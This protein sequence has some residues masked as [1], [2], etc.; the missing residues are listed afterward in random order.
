MSL[1]PVAVG[2]G[3]GS[4]GTLF[5]KLV[6]DILSSPPPLL[7]ESLGVVQED[8]CSCEQDIKEGLQD[9]WGSIHTQV[10]GFH[11]ISVLVGIVIGESL[12][13]LLELIILFRLR[14]NRYVIRAQAQDRGR[15]S[16]SNSYRILGSAL[17]E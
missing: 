17:N 11:L 10:Q 8:F 15:A 16:S 9:L 5:L 6:V 7:P 14:W 13:P 3:S 4:L 2:V 1:R 12:G